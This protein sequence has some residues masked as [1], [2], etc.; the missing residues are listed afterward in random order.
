MPKRI[1]KR[2]PAK[3]EIPDD[4]EFIGM[5]FDKNGYK[6]QVAEFAVK[7]GKIFELDFGI[8][9]LAQRSMDEGKHLVTSWGVD[10]SGGKV[11][12][13]AIAEGSDFI[14]WFHQQ[15][16]GIYENDQIYHVVILTQNE[17]VEVLCSKLPDLREVS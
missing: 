14:D 1:H 16:C 8:S 5:R 17:W 10:V 11:G 15:S 13:I 7:D 6:V 2:F 12:A 3:I 9:P 4:L